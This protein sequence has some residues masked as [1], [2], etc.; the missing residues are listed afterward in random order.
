ML[1]FINYILFHLRM[2]IK[3]VSLTHYSGAFSSAVYN[4]E[5]HTKLMLLKLIT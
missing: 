3:V 1:A 4:Y 2:C 5:N